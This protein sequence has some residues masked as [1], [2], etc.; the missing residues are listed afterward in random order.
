M[1]ESRDIELR[2]RHDIPA[3]QAPDKGRPTTLT[4][5]KSQPVS[6]KQIDAILPFLEAFERMGF[7]CGE[8]PD[9]SESVI[10]HFDFCDP[11]QALYENGM[12]RVI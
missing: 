12:D 9:A 6:S 1:R 3:R 8:W 2:R 4:Q 10:P 11:V 7:R 5:T